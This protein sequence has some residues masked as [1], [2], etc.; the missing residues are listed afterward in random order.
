MASE[1]VTI[2]GHI[3]DSLTLPRVMDEIVE[4]GAT[5]EIVELQLGVKHEDPS[6]ARLKV[7]HDDEEALT[8]LIE[9]LRQHG[10]NPE[11]VETRNSLPPMSMGRSPRASIRAPTSR[12]RYASRADGYESSGPRW[13]AAS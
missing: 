2:E 8:A 6:F 7:T 10:A 13:I 1:T 5:Y 9:R 4:L 11:T 12:P 3:I